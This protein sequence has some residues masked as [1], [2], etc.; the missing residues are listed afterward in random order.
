MTKVSQEQARSIERKSRCQ[1]MKQW[2]LRYKIETTGVLVVLLGAIVILCLVYIPSDSNNTTT[3]APVN[4]DDTNGSDTSTPTDNN[5]NNAPSST[6]P[7]PAPDDLIADSPIFQKLALLSDLQDPLSPQYKAAD[8]LV[9]LDFLKISEKSS[10]LHQRFA[11]ATLYLSTGGGL[12]SRNGSWTRCSAVPPLEENSAEQA[13]SNM[14][15]I[16]RDGK[17]ICAEKGNFETCAFTDEEGVLIQ[18]KRFLSP[19]SECEWY[20]VTCNENGVVTM[21]DIGTFCSVLLL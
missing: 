1:A 15:C 6:P 4:T 9:A 7:G 3:D 20:G 10:S 16:L 18:G 11:L 8:W 14:Q 12:T 17:I 2:I 5:N 13:A 21:I 19:V